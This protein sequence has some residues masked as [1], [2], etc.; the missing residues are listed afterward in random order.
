M[1]IGLSVYQAEG[2][3]IDDSSERHEWKTSALRYL[4]S[5]PP[6]HQKHATQCPDTDSPDR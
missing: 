2:I 1:V 5:H 6:V 3:A 4:L